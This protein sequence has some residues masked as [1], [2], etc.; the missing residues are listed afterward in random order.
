MIN[1]IY[2]EIKK[3]RN[4]ML[5][6]VI[7]SLLF[8]LMYLSFY[9]IFVDQSASFVELF[10]QVDPSLLKGLSI[11]LNVLFTIEGFYGFCLKYVYVIAAIY[12]SYLGFEIFYTE[13]KDQM[14]D[15]LFVRPISRT[16]IFVAKIFSG[17][18]IITLFNILFSVVSY[19]L[20]SYYDTILVSSFLKITGLMYCFMLFIFIISILIL[21]CIRGNLQSASGFGVMLGT[22]FFG[23]DLIGNS[24]ELDQLVK[25]SPFSIFDVQKNLSNFMTVQVMLFIILVCFLSCLISLFNFRKWGR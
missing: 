25:I 21:S 17:V 9:P 7:S 6:Y 2:F 14:L 15:F 19:G 3:N 16:R 12:S 11:D 8:L 5:A 23:I 20:L 24:L 10:N 22:F 18:I 13:K 1:I 4:L